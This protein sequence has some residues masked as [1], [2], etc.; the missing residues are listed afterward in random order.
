M[1]KPQSGVKRMALKP[2]DPLVIK[3]EPPLPVIQVPAGQWS[4]PFLR[5]APWPG[6][7]S[8]EPTW[9]ATAKAWDEVISIVPVGAELWVTV[10]GLKDIRVLDRDQGTVQRTIPCAAAAEAGGRQGHQDHRAGARQRDF[11]AAGHLLPGRADALLAA[12]RGAEKRPLPVERP[13][14]RRQ[15]AARG[16]QR[17][18]PERPQP[19]PVVLDLDGRPRRLVGA[20]GPLGDAPHSGE[21]DR[22]GRPTWSLADEIKVPRP[23]DFLDVE[24]CIYY[25]ATDTM[26]L[27]GMTW[28]HP[29][30]KDWGFGHCGRLTVRY[31]DWSKPTRKIVSRM[32]Y[33]EGVN[34]MRSLT[35]VPQ[36]DRLFVGEMGRPRSSP[37]IPRPAS[38]CGILEPD[39]RLFGPALAWF[40]QSGAI[41]ATARKNGEILIAAEEGLCGKFLIYRLPPGQ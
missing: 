32:V 7:K 13:Q 23:S 8:G 22:H 16:D 27:A 29:G 11:R 39:V 4:R 20:D 18:R 34:T 38:C 21:D 35:I 37:T 33:P 28:D 14:R 15:G 1:G 31:A 9:F 19:D 24:R 30:G 2:G 6:K 12:G 10:G 41:R 40:D 17:A 25:P 36:L 5:E 26:Y 3:D